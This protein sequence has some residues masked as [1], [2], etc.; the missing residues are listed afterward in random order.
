MSKV[1]ATAV[2]AAVVVNQV[3][4]DDQRT[5]S[6]F[7]TAVGYAAVAAVLIGA[8]RLPRRDRLPW[9]LFAAGLGA[10]S[11]G[12]VVR[13][14]LG[15]EVPAPSDPLFLALYPFCAAAIAVL[16]RRREIGRDRTAAVDAATITTGLGLLAWVYVIAPAA[17]DGGVTMLGQA[18]LAA[19]PVGDLILLAMMVRLLRG[20]GARGAPFWWV[21]ASMAAFLI[22]DT[23]WVVLRYLLE[24]GYGVDHVATLN[25]SVESLFLVAMMLLPVGALHPDARWIAAPAGAEGTRLSRVHL[26][27]MAAASLIAPVVLAVQLAQGAVVNGTAIVIC[28]AA[29]FLLVVFRMWQALREV[30]NQA[31]QVRELAR[32]DELTGLPNRRAWNDELPRALESARR[33]GRPVSVAVLDLDR[34]KLF[35][36]TFGHPAGDRLLKSAAA[37]WHGSLR[38]V[39]TLARYGGEEFVVLLPNA[40]ETE[41]CRV[42]ERVLAATPLEQT[43]SAGVAVWDGRET[44]D[45]LIERAD[46]ALYRAKANG[47]NQIAPANDP[48]SNLP[49]LS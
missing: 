22:G 15:G 4:P 42:I 18:T 28:S 44:S 32:C 11:T 29:L 6:A 36:D 48:V 13:T 34:F 26:T 19:Y 41:A 40:G 31:R 3:L 24:V 45:E 43:F 17:A 9:W 39:D 25:R 47:R 30:E 20:R 5:T 35:N 12:I 21:T 46:A 23:A 38:A 37:A 14:V 49:G 7:Q 1:F 2:V 33:D 16:I 27:L 8:S 10:N